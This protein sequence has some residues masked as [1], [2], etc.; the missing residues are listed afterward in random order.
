M[1]GGRPASELDVLYAQACGLTLDEL[2]TL[3][4]MQFPVLQTYERNTWYDRNGR[5]IF[6][7]KTGAGFLPRKRRRAD[8]CYGIDAPQRTRSGI[9]LGW[10]DVRDLKKGTIT[11]A[12]LDDTVPG[13]PVERTITAQAPF[14]R[15]DREA[16][17]EE[18]WHYFE[19]HQTRQS[20]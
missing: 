13:G 5:V 10:E 20:R 16:A 1:P 3:Y 8:T 14:D 7:A 11:C 18:A 6:S 12:I 2:C 9:A 17:Y 4:R 15:C 19:Q